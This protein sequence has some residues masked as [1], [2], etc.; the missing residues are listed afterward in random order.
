MEAVRQKVEVRLRGFYVLSAVSAESMKRV[1]GAGDR[2]TRQQSG[3]EGPPKA[4][5]LKGAPLLL[6]EPF[7]SSRNEGPWG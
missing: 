7:F 2:N 3:S 5:T 4:G 6:T 1:C